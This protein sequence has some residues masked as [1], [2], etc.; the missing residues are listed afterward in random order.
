MI[1]AQV[2]KDLMKHTAVEDMQEK[3]GI[4]ADDL[5]IGVIDTRA[6]DKAKI[7]VL[8]QT[9]F[10]HESVYISKH[11]RFA[12]YPEHTHEFIEINYMLRGE[13]YQVVNGQKIHLKQGDIL[14]MDVGCSH[15][16]SRLNEDD[17]LVNLLFRDHNISFKFL[18]DIHREKSLVYDFLLN[19]SLKNSNAQSF[20]I[21][22]HNKDISLT[23]DK[24]IEE[25]HFKRPF[26]TTVIQSYFNILLAKIMRYY[27]MPVKEINDP[28]QSLILDIIQDISRD[29]VDIT[30]PD[31]ARKYG[32]SENYLSSLIKKL[33]SKTFIQT[34]TKRRLQQA[35]YLLTSTNSS[36]TDISRM[37]GIHNR[38][39]F[40]KKFKEEYGCLPAEYREKSRENYVAIL[41]PTTKPIS[42]AHQAA[43]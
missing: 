3:R 30:L 19:I 14:M 43:K 10:S 42:I 18:N 33:T 41:R 31:L 32:Y 28:K 21:F 7:P 6:S 15:S 35:R 8:N 5:P 39:S 38:N 36:V 22:P 9:L 20:I 12:P 1:N 11:A 23:M 17:I 29:Y 24:M 4:F 37:V 27:P 34:R 26:H 2:M 13:C 25:H 16:I 40:Y